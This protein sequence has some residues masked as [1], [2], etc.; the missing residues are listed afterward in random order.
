MNLK[1]YLKKNIPEFQQGNPSLDSYLDAAGEFLEGIKEAIEH[2]D[3]SHDYESE[4]FNVQ[5]SLKGKGIDLPKGLPFDA[6]KLYLRDFTEFNLKNGT[7]DSLIHSLRMIGFNAEVRRAWL[8]APRTL[9][10]GYMYDVTTGDTRRYDLNKFIYTEMLFGTEEVTEDGVFFKGHTYTDIFRENTLENI[11]IIGERYSGTVEQPFTVSKTPYIIVRFDEGNFNVSVDSYLDPETGEVYNYST[12][13]G[14]QLV[15]E[16]IDYFLKNGRRP[17]TVRVII[18]VSLQPFE[19]IITIEDDY[20]ESHLH[21]VDP[22]LNH[23]EIPLTLEDFFTLQSTYQVNDTAIGTNFIIGFESPYGDPL[24]QIQTPNIGVENYQSIIF[25]NW[26]DS[27]FNIPVNLDKS[28]PNI[29]VRFNTTVVVENTS[30]VSISV[31][32]VTTDGVETLLDTVAAGLNYS[33]TTTQVDQHFIRVEP[34]MYVSEKVNIRIEFSE[35]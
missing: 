26:S 35:N 34:N 3:K 5:M 20:Q 29:I 23:E 17:S 6:K 22:D 14:F 13:E 16:V 12:D 27:V 32:V 1:D 4:I 11:P 30:S 21:D 15:N 28:Y 18:I 8:P 2:F 9:R 25:D 7:E 33:F 19:D 10:K 24:T 31:Y